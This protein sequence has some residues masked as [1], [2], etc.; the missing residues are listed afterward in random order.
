[1]VGEVKIYDGEGNL[2]VI[3]SSQVASK[4]HG[5]KLV[6]PSGPKYKKTRKKYLKPP[7]NPD[8]VLKIP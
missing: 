8:D 3:I 2:K 5:A 6:E 1:M 4:L 7:T